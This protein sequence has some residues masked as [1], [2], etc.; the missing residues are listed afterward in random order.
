MWQ[1]LY[2][3][4]L[5]QAKRGGRYAYG[6]GKFVTV[7]SVQYIGPPLK[8]FA[9]GA[10]RGRPS[11]VP[12]GGQGNTVATITPALRAGMQ[13]RQITKATVRTVRDKG[14][15]AFIRGTTYVPKMVVRD[16][17]HYSKAPIQVYQ[18]FRGGRILRGQTSGIERAIDTRIV[19]LGSTLNRMGLNHSYFGGYLAYGRTL[20]YGGVGAFAA[21]KLEEVRGYIAQ[22]DITIQNYQH[23]IRNS[24]VP[25]LPVPTAPVTGN[26]VNVPVVPVPVVRNPIPPVLP[27]APVPKGRSGAPIIITPPYRK[28]R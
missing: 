19:R 4:S 6:T 9:T 22:L 8:Q 17:I 28:T 13:V 2:Q 15:G 27:V 21:G 26:S 11:Y 3:L 18:T 20:I 14:P 1:W 12:L 16:A 5:Q 24:N 7:R 25:K 10:I 23:R